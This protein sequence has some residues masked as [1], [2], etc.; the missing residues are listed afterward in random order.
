MERYAV[1]LDR[2]GTVIEER[3]YLGRPEQVRLLPGA[4]EGLQ[5]LARAGFDLFL[6]TNQSGVGRGYFTMEDVARVH[7]R[8]AELLEPFGI[9][10]AG[11]YVAPEAPD[12]PSVGRKPSPYYLFQAQQQHGID[13]AQSYMI[14][15]KLTDL[16][17]GWNAGVKASILVLTGYGPEAQQLL[18]QPPPGP[19]VVAQDLAAAADWILASRH[20]TQGGSAA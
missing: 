13:L 4:A 20:L 15:D 17:C 12:Q 19:V 1:F 8:L 7:D 18:P 6:V 9:R 5:R 2:D 10:F 11:I 3:G 14:G 16:Q